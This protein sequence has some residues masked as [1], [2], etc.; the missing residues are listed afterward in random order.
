MPSVENAYFAC[1][2]VARALVVVLD[3]ARLPT[4][5][6]TSSAV[7]VA[8]SRSCFRVARHVVVVVGSEQTDIVTD[9]VNTQET[10]YIGGRNQH[11]SHCFRSYLP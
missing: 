10:P 1:S 8:G 9:D 2:L 3:S 4:D 6:E 7:L 5:I 11:K